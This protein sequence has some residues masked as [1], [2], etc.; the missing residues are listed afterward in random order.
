MTHDELLA[1]FDALAAE[2]K[3]LAAQAATAEA[4]LKA[5]TKPRAPGK[6]TFKVSRPF[7]VK[8]T[9]KDGVE[10]EGKGTLSLYGLTAKFPISLYRK[11][12]LRLKEVVLNGDLDKALA[13][14]ATVMAPDR[15]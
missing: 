11:Q 4:A 1:K 10:E 15:D 13:E 5:A 3:Q 6:L 14:N 7:G 9:N 12:W 2:N 8:I